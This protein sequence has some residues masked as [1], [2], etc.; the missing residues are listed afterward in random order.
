M[1]SCSDPDLSS[2]R[3]R[4]CLSLLLEPI[5]EHI[6]Y[7]RMGREPAGCPTV[8]AGKSS[9]VIRIGWLVRVYRLHGG[10]E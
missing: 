1:T 3:A 8:A 2:R 7:N 5:V 6:H 10:Q 9:A 4:F